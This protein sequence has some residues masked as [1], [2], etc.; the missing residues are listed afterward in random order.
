MI[1]LNT[2][3]LLVVVAILSIS[4]S[5]VDSSQ[6]IPAR[7]AKVLSVA[8]PNVMIT[9]V[10]SYYSLN[11]FGNTL[12]IYNFQNEKAIL[13]INVDNITTDFNT[14]ATIHIFADNTNDDSIAKWV[15]NQHSDALFSDAPSPTQSYEIPANLYSV[16]YFFLIDQSVG[17]RGDTY[18]NYEIDLL[19]ENYS[20]AGIFDLERF[21][22][23]AN[24][25]I[26]TSD[27]TLF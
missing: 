22:T 15:N 17:D 16:T 27:I 11:R 2:I 26:L 4:C 20:I 24:V 5:S 1:K 10:E 9:N 13:L 23:K 8:A 3:Y 12:R 21:T 14:S 7:Q 19:F 18:D 25:H 6:Q